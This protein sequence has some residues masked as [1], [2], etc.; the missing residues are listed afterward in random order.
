[1]QGWEHCLESLYRPHSGFRGCH[2]K[3]LVAGHKRFCV[4]GSPCANHAG[5]KEFQRM[6]PH[7]GVMLAIH[8]PFVDLSGIEVVDETVKDHVGGDGAEPVDLGRS[9]DVFRLHDLSR[10][11]MISPLEHGF[12]LLWSEVF[13]LQAR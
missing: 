5:A 3:K 11:G 4:R 10:Y 6:I 1:M 7:G 9:L 8:N 2:L 12:N 13:R